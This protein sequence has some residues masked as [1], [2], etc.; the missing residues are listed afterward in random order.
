MP[1]A[2]FSVDTVQRWAWIPPGDQLVDQ[3]GLDQVGPGSGACRRPTLQ[4]CLATSNRWKAAVAA[5]RK[6]SRHLSG[7]TRRLSSR[8]RFSTSCCRSWQPTLK[9]S[10]A[11]RP[12][13]SRSLLARAIRWSSPRWRSPKGSA[14]CPEG[15][16][17]SERRSDLRRF[18]AVPWG[19]LV[20]VP[21]ADLRRAGNAGP[22]AP[23]LAGRG[24][25]SASSSMRSPFSA[26]PDESRPS[27][28]ARAFKARLLS[29][30]RL[31]TDRVQGGDCRGAFCRRVRH[32]EAKRRRRDCNAL[33][34]L[35]KS[36]KLPEG[37]R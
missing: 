16:D 31:S 22:A 7:W 37:G 8:N 18:C 21:D 35:G 13:T 26:H 30:P 6:S 15:L 4:R 19:T 17:C 34:M 11:A 3:G 28:N 2:P 32:I 14:Q 29:R 1:Q 24:P 9:K 10:S 5:S 23:E 27:S 25:F 33:M 20:A 12:R 36:R